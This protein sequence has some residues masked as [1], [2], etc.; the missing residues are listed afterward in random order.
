MTQLLL[1]ISPKPAPSLENFVAGRNAELLQMLRDV[2]AEKQKECFI[3][4]WGSPGSGRSHLLKAVVDAFRG[5]HLSASYLVCNTTAEFILGLDQLDCVA[6]DD[7]ERLG[8]PGQIGL[9]NLY[10]HI[11]ESGHTVL[12]V[13]GRDVPSQLPLREDLVTRLGWGLVY[14]VHGLN[15]EEKAEALRSHA[16]ARGFSFPR[17]VI[18]YLLRH[19]RRD[20]PSLLAML[21]ALDRYSLQTKRPITVPMLKELMQAS[22]PPEQR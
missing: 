21:D 12:L 7:V 16:Q 14:K 17:D 15:D 1:D 20:L 9:F 5:K 13:S 19:G 8:P 10:N 11:R 2:L 4:L 3:Y 6:V 22:S 18:D